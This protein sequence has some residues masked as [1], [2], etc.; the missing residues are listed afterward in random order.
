MEKINSIKQEITEHRYKLRQIE[1]NLKSDLEEIVSA[2]RI[3]LEMGVVTPE[4]V[5]FL[6]GLT[7]EQIKK[8]SI[9][10][11]KELYSGMKNINKSIDNHLNILTDSLN[12]LSKLD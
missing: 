12:E 5:Q 8:S 6:E 9:D 11:F 4:E 2:S 7:A 1:E 3:A 10:E